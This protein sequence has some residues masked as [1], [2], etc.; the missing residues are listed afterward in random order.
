MQNQLHHLTFAKPVSETISQLIIW[1]KSDGRHFQIVSQLF[2]LCYGI[3]ALGWDAEWLNFL[4]AFT[5]ALGM[6]FLAIRFAGVPDHSIK[7]AM[8]TS[9]GLS[10]LFKAND[11][12][13]FLFAGVLAISQKFLLR[14]NGKHLWNP[15]N[16]GIVIMIIASGEGWIAPGLWGSSALLV[17]IIGTAGLAVLSNIKRLDTG[18]FFILTLAVLEFSRTVLYLG[19]DFDVF[20]HKLSSGSLWLFAFF[21]I[22]DPMTSPNHKVMRRIWAMLVAAVSFYLASFYFI[23]A[24]PFW[25]LFFATPL[26]PLFDLLAKR[27]NFLWTKPQ[28]KHL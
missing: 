25:V 5:G 28:F 16:F 26:V 2:F 15:A 20:F 27:E 3:Q 13:L 18:I 21:M 22:T 1:L 7:S 12:L 19:W 23:N 10:L 8:I 4:S 24:A 6:Q 17:F 11:P 9:L 14:I